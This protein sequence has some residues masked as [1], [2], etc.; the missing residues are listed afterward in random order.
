MKNLLLAFFLFSIGTLVAQVGE[1][2]TEADIN[3]QAQIVK[4]TQKKLLRKYDDA[5][6]IYEGILEQNRHNTA[7]LFDLSRIYLSQND[8]DKAIEFGE[9]ALKKEPQN[10]WYKES[11]AEIK[12]QFKYFLEAGKMYQDLAFNQKTNQDLY[13]KAIEAYRLA[14]NRNATLAVFEKMEDALGVSSFTSQQ[15]IGIHLNEENYEK[16]LAKAAEL[17]NIYHY[18]PEYLELNA[19]LEADFGSNQE[20]KRLFQELLSVDPENSKALVYL[21]KKEGNN[22]DLG[23]VGVIVSNPNVD[24]DSKVKALIPYAEIITEDYPNKTMILSFAK[25]IVDHHPEEAKAYALYGDILNNSGDLENAEKQ[26]SSALKL[27]KSVYV[28]WEQLM[29][30]QYEQGHYVELNKTSSN[31][32]DFYPNQAAPY[33]FQGLANVNMDEYDIGKEM[34]SEA[35]LIGTKSPFINSIIDTLS[36]TLEAHEE[37]DEIK[38]LTKEDLFMRGI[39]I[40][41]PSIIKT[42]SDGKYMVRVKKGSQ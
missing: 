12:M 26:Y 4:A 28:I 18:D 27:D 32:L 2:Y 9:K 11:L 16:A 21:A 34:L 7:V 40:G 20:A 6:K 13:F 38:V 14:D 19:E 41:D 17:I 35:L 24:I 3:I 30:I 37:G 39:Q 36:K 31:A 29:F 10:A 33:V 22:D 42:T 5:I 23:S 25:D 8:E 15:I 1:R